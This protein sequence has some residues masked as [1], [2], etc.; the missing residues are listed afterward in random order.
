MLQYCDYTSDRKKIITDDLLSFHSVYSDFHVKKGWGENDCETIS[1]EG[2]VTVNNNNTL[3]E[4]PLSFC[5]PQQ[6]PDIPP[7]CRVIPKDHNT[8]IQSKYIDS[9]GMISVEIL[10]NWNRN[11]DSLDIM[12][13][14]CEYFEEHIPVLNI[15]D[16]FISEMWK[17]RTQIDEL[18]KEKNELLKQNSLY[19]ECSKQLGTTARLARPLTTPPQIFFQKMLLT[20]SGLPN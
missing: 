7:L 15:K 17:V 4:V 8:I 19:L 9:Y 1:V 5:F 18:C 20:N 16:C 12:Q 10:R 11:S 13:K 14:C 3:I 6:Y 2:T